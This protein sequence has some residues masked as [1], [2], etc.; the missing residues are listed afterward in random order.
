[1]FRPILP[2]GFHLVPGKGA[3]PYRSFRGGLEKTN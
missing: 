3:R 2:V 1:M